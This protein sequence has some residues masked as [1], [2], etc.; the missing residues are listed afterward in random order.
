MQVTRTCG[1]CYNNFTLTPAA[2]EGRESRS[3]SGKIFCSQQCG[4]AYNKEQRRREKSKKESI[5]SQAYLDGY[6]DTNTNT[7]KSDNDMRSDLLIQALEM[8]KEHPELTPDEVL[9][10]VEAKENEK[11]AGATAIVEAPAVAGEAPSNIGTIPEDL[12]PQQNRS[13][14]S[15]SVE[16]AVAMCDAEYWDASKKYPMCAWSPEHNKFAYWIVETTPRNPNEKA[17]GYIPLVMTGQ[18]VANSCYRCNGTGKM[19][20]QS[21]EGN[22]KQDTKAGSKTR[23]DAKT[24]EEYVLQKRLDFPL[25]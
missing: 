20:A 25:V 13:A 10:L 17:R 11:P 3:K 22:Y 12:L 19:T 16:D 24:L 6:F 15:D 18:T 14:A 7:N 5:E 9:E 4:P 21:L 8:Q 1:Y 2:A 23:T